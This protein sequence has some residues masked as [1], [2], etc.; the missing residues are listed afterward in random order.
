M[1]KIKNLYS[2]KIFSSNHIPRIKTIIWITIG[3]TIITLFQFGQGFLILFQVDCDMTDIDAALY[4]KGSIVTGIVA[5]LIGGTSIVYLWE[6]WLRNK[7][8]A[9]ALISIGVSYTIVFFTVSFLT[10]LFF[11]IEESGYELSNPELWNLIFAEMTNMPTLQNY[12][13]WLLV[14]IG[15]MFILIISDKFG[16][17]VFKSMITGKYFQP[18]REERVFMFLDLRSST[19]IAEKLGEVQ[20][21]KFLNDAFRFAT[22]GIISSQGQ[23]YQY[24]GDEIV[25]SWPLDK[26]IEKANCITCFIHIQKSMEEKQEY[27]LQQYGVAPQFKAG[28]HYGHVMAGEM[29]VLKRDIVFSGD[30]LN[31]AS[32]IQSKCNE[33]GVNILM[34]KVLID[35]VKAKIS[36]FAFKSVGKLHLK[37]KAMDM[38]LYTI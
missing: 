32:R 22:S 11:I 9:N 35:K 8:Y 12:P 24:V 37:G 15:T 1:E 4:F 16:T 25:I 27:F 31:T 18:Q 38:S 36:N 19:A 5:G 26:G 29:G 21:F 2:G 28:L 6:G 34:S 10:S 13:F 7:K 17:G 14:V 23:I 20:Y 3:W 33:L 30:V